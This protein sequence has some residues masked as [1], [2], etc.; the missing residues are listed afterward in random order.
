MKKKITLFLTLILSFVCVLSVSVFGALADTGYTVEVQ[1]VAVTQG[2]KVT[3]NYVL[4]DAQTGKQI[5]SIMFDGPNG[6]KYST[7][8][9]VKVFNG[10]TLLSEGESIVIDTTD[11]EIGKLTLKLSVY[12]KNDAS[13]F[14]FGSDEFTLEIKKQDKTMTYVMIGFIVLIVG[15]LIWSNYSN[16]KKQKK[17][18][19]QLST[20]KVGD[21]VKTIGGVCGFVTEI[22]DLEN[23]FVLEVGGSNKK[24]YVKFDKGAIY[25][26]A[27]AN[28]SAVETAKTEEKPEPKKKEQP[29]EITLEEKKED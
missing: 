23:T 3:I 28:G 9:Y 24:S 1:D 15:Y 2:T 26:T 22:N 27:P 4:K 13:A 11:M 7:K 20:L 8:P 16:K 21:R 14:E 19:S 18:Q 25:Q 10:Q 6:I 12:D 29:A 17:A 5:D